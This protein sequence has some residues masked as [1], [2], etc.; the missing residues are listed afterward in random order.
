MELVCRRPGL[1]R[2]YGLASSRRA[3][4]QVWEQLLVDSMAT[5]RLVEMP[6]RPVG[7]RICTFGISAFVRPAV[8]THFFQ[9][10][11]PFLGEWLIL[12]HR[13][14]GMMFMTDNEVA[15]ANA[16]D[17]LLAV[18]VAL[19]WASDGI[20]AE[21]L[22]AFRQWGIRSF[23]EAHSGFR[24]RELVS[25]CFSGPEAAIFLGSGAWTVRHTF[26]DDQDLP[27]II[28]RTREEALQACRTSQV[29]SDLFVWRTPRYGFSRDQ[30][31]FLLQALDFPTD[32]ELAEA[33]HVSE[34]AVAR[35]WTRIF[36]R[37]EHLQSSS[38]PVFTASAPQ[39]GRRARLL[40][41]L[42]NEMHELRPHTRRQPRD[43]AL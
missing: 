38:D 28:G 10:P 2:R 36:R 42:V 43:R 3:L 25:E 40:S 19:G 30:Q 18:T 12:G 21:D 13:D 39:G 41:R 17:G 6:E 29:T 22:P 15:S 26:G 1:G 7:A 33:L 27:M 11:Q 8:L 4:L 23:S 20:P 31:N 37:V 5:S 34:H 16:H 35:R 14:T 9:T 24:L 32:R